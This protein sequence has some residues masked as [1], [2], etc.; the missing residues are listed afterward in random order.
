MEGELCDFDIIVISETNLNDDIK[1][2][3]ILLKGFQK[4]MVKIEIDMEGC[5]YL[6][7]E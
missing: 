7:Q 6:Y 2:E 5:S 4:P 1:T 3:D